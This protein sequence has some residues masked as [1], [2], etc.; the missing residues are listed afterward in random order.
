[1]VG[2]QIYSLPRWIGKAYLRSLRRHDLDPVRSL[3]RRIASQELGCPIGPDRVDG[4]RV[5]F[6]ARDNDVLAAGIDRETARLL[7]GRDVCEPGEPSARGINTERR[8][9]VAGAFDGVQET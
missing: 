3:A 6:F 8:K 1:M 7:L 9:R 4:D 5:R 2:I